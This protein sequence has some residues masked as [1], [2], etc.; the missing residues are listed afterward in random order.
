MLIKNLTVRDIHKDKKLSSKFLII[1]SDKLKI[2]CKI[3][4]GNFY[5][6]SF[7]YF[8]ILSE[9]FSSLGL[10]LWNEK[11]K[12]NHFFTKNFYSNFV[13]NKKKF[14]ANDGVIVLGSSPA[15]NYYRNLISFIPRIIFITDKQIS[16]AIHRN[17]SNKIREFIKSILKVRGIKLKKFV[18]LD[19]EFYYFKNSLIPQFFQLGNAVKILSQLSIKN[20]NKNKKRIYLTRKNAFSRTIVN[21]TEIFDILKMKNFQIIDTD[22]LTVNKQIEVF[23]KAE[24]VI[25]PTGSALANIV[26]CKKGTKVVEIMPKYK[27]PYEEKYY[28]STLLQVFVSLLG[29]KYFFIEG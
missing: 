10:F 22:T 23:S 21:E 4:K 8:P 27:F 9:N 26:F 18:Y 1:N 28:K 16:L 17:T 20:I 24:I 15:D 19:N 29:L 14:K 13:K 25:G 11:N 3:Y 6:D 5:I 12:Y 7:N 2:S